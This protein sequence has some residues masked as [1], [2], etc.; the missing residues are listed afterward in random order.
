MALPIHHSLDQH[1]MVVMVVMLVGVTCNGEE[2][3]AVGVLASISTFFTK[4][5]LFEG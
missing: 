1:D 3:A 5:H 4:W 2:M